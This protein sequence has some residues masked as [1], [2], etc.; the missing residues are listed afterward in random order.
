MD[1][2]RSSVTS[3][4]KRTTSQKTVSSQSPPCKPQILHS[5]NRLDSLRNVS[6]VRYERGY[7]IPEDGIL[8]SHRRENL[9]SYIA[10]TGWAL[11]R[12]RNVIPVRYELGYYITEDDIHYSHRRENLK[13]YIAL[14]DWAL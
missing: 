9:K 1:S 4:L 10:L 12:R 8:H 14:T 13:S 7:Y 2:I 11:R 6:L 3:V 5:I